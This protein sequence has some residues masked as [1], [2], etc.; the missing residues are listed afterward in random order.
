[1][2]GREETKKIEPVYI[3]EECG[4]EYPGR[5]PFPE[6]CKCGNY[7]EEFFREKDRYDAEDDLV[8]RP[9]L[10]I[11]YDPGVLAER[12]KR[13]NVQKEIVTQEIADKDIQLDYRRMSKKQLREWLSKLSPKGKVGKSLL[14]R[15]KKELI[16]MC[17]KKG[18]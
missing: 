5:I 2:V 6:G 10:G 8:G 16:E 1:M 3:C 14:R 11:K 17:E 7:C 9:L 18:G 4:R 15:T 13:L 12:E